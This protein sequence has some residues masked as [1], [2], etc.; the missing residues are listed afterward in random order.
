M[1]VLVALAVLM[2]LALIAGMPRPQP[3]SSRQVTRHVTLKKAGR[4]DLPGP[5]ELGALFPELLKLPEDRQIAVSQALGQIAA[6]C[7]PCWREADLRLSECLLRE[8][9]GCEN[10]PY[11]VRRVIAAAAVQPD[12]AALRLLAVRGD[13]WVPGV[14]AP[15]DGAP[16]PVELWLDLS[17]PLLG[18]ALDTLDAVEK[19]PVP[20]TLNLRSYASKSVPRPLALAAE[21]ARQAGGLRELA[22]CLAAPGAADAS[23]ACQSAWESAAQA[24]ELAQRL[25]EEQALAQQRG[26][27]SGPTWFVRGYRMRGA[28]S[29]A[30]LNS[31]LAREAW[32]PGQPVP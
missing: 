12:A 20:I 10:L 14:A 31:M 29:V 32:V 17:S 2:G 7:G 3:R 19:G 8:E 18:V 4:R 15:A 5:Q 9:K 30:A 26:V 24:P 21:A 28:Q 16:V 11:L 25:E 1:L 22:H 13:L 23:G 6:P 27:R